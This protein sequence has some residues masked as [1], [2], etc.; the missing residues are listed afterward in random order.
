MTR[1][2]RRSSRRPGF[3]TIEAL[4]A[5]VVFLLGLS[6]L[7]GALTQARNS[8]GQARRYMQASDLASDTLEQVQLWD[9][10]D[11]RLTPTPGVCSDDPTDNGGAL[12]KDPTSSEFK[13]YRDC[14][15]DETWLTKTSGTRWG[16]ILTPSFGDEQGSASPAQSSFARYYTVRL[17]DVRPGVKRMQIFVKV[18]YKE[19]G[20]QR[21]ASTQAMRM[22]MGL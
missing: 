15:H 11:P 12:T 6:G 16:G 13:A 8:T 5:A 17:Q 18:L 1:H 4:I 22:Q 21:V 3:T 9:F 7:L 20:V 19:E 14:M 2:I 10:T